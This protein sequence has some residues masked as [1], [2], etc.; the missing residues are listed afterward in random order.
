M[1]LD[2]IQKE[3]GVTKVQLTQV[4]ILSVPFKILSEFYFS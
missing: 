3:Y 2:V 1:S 4:Q